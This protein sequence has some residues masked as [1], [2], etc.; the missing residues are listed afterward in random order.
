[1]QANK[2]THAS[3]EPTKNSKGQLWRLSSLATCYRQELASALEAKDDL[4]VGQ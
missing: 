1:M 4:T 3:S 2:Q